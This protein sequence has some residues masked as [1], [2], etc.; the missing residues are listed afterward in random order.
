MCLQSGGVSVGAGVFVFLSS[1]SLA[2]WKTTKKEVEKKK[3]LSHIMLWKS[4]LC[5]IMNKSVLFK[6]SGFEIC[7][8]AQLLFTKLRSKQFPFKCSCG[9]AMRLVLIQSLFVSQWPTFINVARSGAKPIWSLTLRSIFLQ[10]FMRTTDVS[11][12][13][14]MPPRH[15]SVSRC[16]AFCDVAPQ[17]SRATTCPPHSSIRFCHRYFR[18]NSNIIRL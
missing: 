13:P 12:G 9:P 14:C 15:S 6:Q 8:L 17:M 10:S 11:D 4:H 18:K 16:S 5:H 7:C 2:L 1:S 3:M